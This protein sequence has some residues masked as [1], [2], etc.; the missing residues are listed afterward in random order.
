MTPR[1]RSQTLSPA[2]ILGWGLLPRAPETFPIAKTDLP[3]L[4]FPE[5]VLVKNVLDAYYESPTPSSA[6]PQ[7]LQQHCAQNHWVLEKAQH[8]YVLS[9]LRTHAEDFGPLRAFF[10]HEKIEEIVINGIGKDFPV[11]VYVANEGWKKTPL[12]FSTAPALITLINR[13][14]IE[15]GK[16]LSANTPTLNA[17]LKD[18]SRLH[19]S[20]APV[21][22]SEVEA[23]IR[24]FVFRPHAPRALIDT[25]ILTPP[26]LAYLLTALQTDCNILIVGNTGSG[27]TTTLNALLHAL[28]PNERIITVEETPELQLAHPHVVRLTPHADS[29]WGMDALIRETLRMRPDRVVVGEIRFP[30][31][32]HAFMEAI[33]A[34]QGKGTYATFHGH[35]GEEALSRLRQFG[36]LEADMPWL[37]ILVLQKRWTE[38]SEDNIPL[39]KRGIHE[40]LEVIPTSTK[41]TLTRP[42]FSYAP[43]AQELIPQNESEV[44]RKKFALSFPKRKWELHIAEWENRLR[45]DARAG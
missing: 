30:N 18:G 22:V 37:N 5:A 24:K 40:I 12:Y 7:L 41:N 4:S 43:H 6:L 20:I 27:K 8:D 16:R 19:A 17:R 23:S 26:A 44:V 33:L 21:C 11:N 31:E 32:A 14:A 39:E 2:D 38:Y 25:H 36:I 15:S 35:S 29:K 1:S 45:D 34:G 28:P 10:H 13:L 9:V 3:L 42:I